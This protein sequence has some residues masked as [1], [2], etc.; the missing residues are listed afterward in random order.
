MVTYWRGL[1]ASEVGQ[2]PLSSWTMAKSPFSR[3]SAAPAGGGYSANDAWV[4]ICMF[5][6][7]WYNRHVWLELGVQG[8][9]RPGKSLSCEY[10]EL[11]RPKAYRKSLILRLANLSKL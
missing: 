6:H 8:A 3:T 7:T 9:W 5:T 1:R 11:P 2:I 4:S 10:R